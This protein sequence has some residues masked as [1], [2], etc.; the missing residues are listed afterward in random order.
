MS[1]EATNPDSA[2]GSFRDRRGF[3]RRPPRGSAT[4]VPADKIM[5]PSVI[6]SLINL[7]QGGVHFLT[8][9]ELAVGQRILVE[10]LAPGVG[11]PL[12]VQAVVRWTGIDAKSGKIRVGCSWYQRLGY[13]DLVG[14][15]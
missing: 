12:K 10:L 14:F 6:V 11:K 7:S 3:P 15:F 1:E 2:S 5:A 13:G 9:K 4:I 8:A